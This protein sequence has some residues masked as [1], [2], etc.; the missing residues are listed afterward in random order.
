ML[1][2][3]LP[4][5]VRKFLLRRWHDRSQKVLS[6]ML[7][8]GGGIL[9]A[10]VFLHLL[11]DL[12]DDTQEAIENDYITGGRYPMAEL[13]LCTGFFIMYILE[14]IVHYWVHRQQDNGDVDD[15]HHVHHHGHAHHHNTSNVSES[16]ESGELV[17]D[18]SVCR[19]QRK[20]CESTPSVAVLVGCENP[21]VC[22]DVLDNCTHNTLNKAPADVAKITVG[23]QN[24]DN[25]Y[26]S[27]EEARLQQISMLR[28]ILM[29]I[30]LSIHGCLEGLSLGLS[31][32]NADV[33]LVFAA[34]TVHKIAISFSVGMELL[35]KHVRLIYHVFYMVIFSL[36]SPFGGIIGGL[37]LEFSDSSSKTGSLS[38]L[39]LNSLSGGAIMFVV[40]C[41]ILERERSKSDGRFIRLI[42]LVIGF[43]LMASL[44]ILQDEHDVSD[45]PGGSPNNTLKVSPLLYFNFG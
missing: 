36:A 3:H 18:G 17:E 37:L 24:Q 12:L 39:F 33:W 11:P 34:L 28:T 43:M 41:E 2:G 26:D 27:E 21:V 16:F 25:S 10:T 8:F 6:A 9:M 14:E 22:T 32:N 40:F 7:C 45:S 5:I 42:A 1:V 30:A 23:N 4:I 20:R 13:L 38:I 15:H 31:E 29:V 35:E 19:N 44:Q